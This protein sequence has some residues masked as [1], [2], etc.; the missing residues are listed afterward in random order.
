MGGYPSPNN[1][2]HKINELGKK[3]V[4]PGW[5]EK[6]GGQTLGEKRGHAG[7]EEAKKKKRKTSQHNRCCRNDLKN[8]IKCDGW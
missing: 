3:G 1:R 7:R 8:K 2:T 4:K 5:W 6:R